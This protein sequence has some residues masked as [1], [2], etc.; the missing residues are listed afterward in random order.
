MSTSWAVPTIPSPLGAL[1]LLS[2]AVYASSLAKWRARTRG[3]SLPPGP[4]RYP[5][6]GTLFFWHKRDLW[7][8]N[9]ILHE[10]YGTLPHDYTRS[11]S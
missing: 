9:Q 2:L 11:T 8:A 1:L 3:H 4:R 6:I 7:E 5:F 10:N